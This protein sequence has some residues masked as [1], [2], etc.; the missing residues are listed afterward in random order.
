M[1]TQTGP[2]WLISEETGGSII[3]L[4][5]ILIAWFLAA[6]F[7]IPLLTEYGIMDFTGTL[8]R[9]I[10]KPLFH[11]P[12]RAAIDLL[13]SWVGNCNVGVVLTTKQYE[14]GYYTDREAILIASCFSATSLPF[15]LVIAAI[16]GVDQYFIQLY[17]ILSLVGTLSA[18][19]MSRI[20]PL[21]GKWKDEYYPPVGRKVQEVH[22]VGISR[23]RWA[24]HQAIKELKRAH[25]LP[26]GFKWN[27]A[28]PQYHFH[29]G[30]SYHV[31]RNTG[32]LSVILYSTLPMD[33]PAVSVVFQTLWSERICSRSSRAVVGF[34]DMFIPAM[35]CAGITSMKT[36]FVICILSLVQIIYM[37]EVGSIMLNSKLPITIM[38][39]AIIFS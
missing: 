39:L 28:I 34:V 3:Q 7:L 6:S 23:S 22:P 9:N 2:D 11:L 19:I 20:W 18:M 26:A 33:C 31:H 29:T 38:D 37:T 21:E 10:L 14:S 17:F 13:A 8:L 16:M 15:C 25:L 12:G 4:M 24:L 32:L 30:T 36:R 35:I 27:T 5:G 1:A